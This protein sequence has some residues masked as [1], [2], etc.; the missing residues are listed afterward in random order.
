MDRGGH[1]SESDLEERISRLEASQAKPYGPDKS[2]KSI[3]SLRSIGGFYGGAYPA[4]ILHSGEIASVSATFTLNSLLCLPFYMPDVPNIVTKIG[5][6]V[7][8][9]V[10]DKGYRLGIYEDKGEA[11]LYP[12][13]LIVD[14]GVVSAATTGVK[15]ITIKRGLKRGL[16]WLAIIG[17]SSS[18][19]IAAFPL[20]G[21]SWAV[22]G[23][24]EDGTIPYV[25]I[26]V[27]QAYGALP[28]PYP[29]GGIE[30][31]LGIPYIFLTF[32]T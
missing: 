17:N 15:S 19:Q 24:S 20:G 23:H 25:G 12:H 8:F 21:S 27:N 28:D 5:L 31:A 6:N 11:K 4:G 29:T 2:S 3:F 13:K 22:L 7:T 18:V 10:A 14:A 26:V 16:Y 32:G 9:A 30:Y 1:R